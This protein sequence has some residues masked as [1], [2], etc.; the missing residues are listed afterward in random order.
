[1]PLFRLVSV[2]AAFASWVLILLA[3]PCA[4]ED[5]ASPGVVEVSLRNGRTLTGE[6]DSGTD[7]AQLFLRL[8]SPRILIVSRVAWRDVLWVGSTQ[9]GGRAWS[10]ESLR[11]WARSR[12][13]VPA[14][15]E[16]PADGTPA[17]PSALEAEPF[18]PPAGIVPP[19][20][21]GAKGP[22]PPFFP[23]PL[24]I[25]LEA[26]SL[27]I[28][29]K[30]ANWDADAED[31]GV[32]VRLFPRAANGMLAPVVGAVRVRLIGQHVATAG[33]RDLR[34]GRPL[35]PELGQWSV[36]VRPWQFDDWGA[37]RRFPWQRIDPQ[38][39]LSVGSDGQVIV[40]LG[41]TGGRTLRAS[42][43]VRLRSP[44]PLQQ[45]WQALEGTAQFRVR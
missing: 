15:M 2:A 9:P 13:L 3:G 8:S 10:P 22:L 23:P 14:S 24:L 42:A 29:V 25:P 44:S 34:I 5:A 4:A 7:D 1:V 39:D 21:A 19:P 20:L 35:F 12:E 37:V 16:V 30:T 33:A 11:L 41:V 28:D 43:P 36:L 18:V 45:Q 17:S 26:Q 40:E 27:S 6:V 31:D 32:E 38:S